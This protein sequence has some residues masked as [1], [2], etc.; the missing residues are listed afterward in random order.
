MIDDISPDDKSKA[1]IYLKKA[2]KLLKEHGTIV[3]IE[4]ATS[5]VEFLNHLA[6]ISLAVYIDG[7]RST[8]S[9]P[10]HKQLLTRDFCF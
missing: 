3:T 7:R 1:P 6:E 10:F 8:V 4:Q 5:I 2:Q 9:T